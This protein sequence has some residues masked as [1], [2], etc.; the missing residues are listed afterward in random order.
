MH[1]GLRPNRNVFR[2]IHLNHGEYV[3]HGIKAVKEELEKDEQIRHK[4]SL[5]YLS[6]KLLEMDNDTEKVAESLPNGKDV[7]TIRDREAAYIKKSQG[8]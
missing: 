4:Y 5:R 3:E 6:I 8:R 1:T 2:H 7:I